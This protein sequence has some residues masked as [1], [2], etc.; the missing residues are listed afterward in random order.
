MTRTGISGVVEYRE[1]NFFGGELFA[2]SAVFAVLP[3]NQQFFVGKL[4]EKPVGHGRKIV[5]D[6]FLAGRAW[7]A[8]TALFGKNTRAKNNYAGG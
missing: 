1:I 7:T 2:N 3:S 8:W 4:S 6:G 5:C